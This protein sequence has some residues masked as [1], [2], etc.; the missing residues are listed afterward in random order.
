MID[1]KKVLKLAEEFITGSDKYIVDLQVN[2]NN[3]I[4]LFVDAD[5]SVSISDC[6]ELSR[7]I[8][9]NL[10]REIEDFELNVS[11]AGLD[12]P[13]KVFKQ[14]QKNINKEVSVL[15][16]DGKKYQG[17][18]VSATEEAITLH[19]EANKKRKIEAQELNFS[20]NEIKE[21]KSTI[22]FKK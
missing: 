19:I 2:S 15:L 21:T 20:M 16:Q 11:S 5:E 4:H 13:F 22:S 6:I 7:H 3:I 17:T 1:K 9:S 14:Y 8:E 10:D 18:L 12:Q